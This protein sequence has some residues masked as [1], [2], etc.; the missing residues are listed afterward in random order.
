MGLPI[1]VLLHRKGGTK[2]TDLACQ[3]LDTVAAWF[4]DRHIRCC[5]DGAFASCLIPKGN[6]RI[7]FISRIRRDAALLKL[8]CLALLRAAARPTPVRCEALM[9]RRLKQRYAFP[10]SPMLNGGLACVTAQR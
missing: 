8:K 10:C 9:R 1:L 7:T 3:A 6:H 2:L 4:P 5:S